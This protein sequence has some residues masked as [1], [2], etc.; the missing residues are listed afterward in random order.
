M[1]NI[2]SLSTNGYPSQ[3]RRYMSV[4]TQEQAQE[5]SKQGVNIEVVDLA[6]NI[7]EYPTNCSEEFSGIKVHRIHPVKF[8]KPIQ[9]ISSINYLRKVVLE[10][11]FNLI[12]CSFLD[13]QYIKY[14]PWIFKKKKHELFFSIM[15]RDA[16]TPSGSIKSFIKRKIKR[17]LFNMATFTF[18][19][20]EYTET[21]LSCLIKRKKSDSQKIQVVYCGINEKKFENVYSKTKE[22]LRN[23]LSLPQDKFIIITVCQ[24]IE[25]KGVIPLVNGVLKSLEE[26]PNLLHIIVGNGAEETKLR[27]LVE[28]SSFKN[29][30]I[31][32]SNLTDELLSQYFAASD[33]YAM[34]SKTLWEILATEGFG[35]SYAE[36]SY[37][38]IPVIC[39]KDGGG[40]LAVQNNFTG[41]WIDPNKN[42]CVSEISNKINLLANDI[43]EYERVSKNGKLYVSREF[44]WSKNVSSILEI[45]ET[46]KG[47]E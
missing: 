8:S 24:L 26:N 33:L 25:R 44:S 27:S 39:G 16:M 42:N 19:I 10:G 28:N 46:L 11:N 37:L 32:L 2:I 9:S 23:D 1:I 30:F 34:I 31:F 6:P 4:F 20:S 18:P 36:A 45:Y 40:T 47:H 13:S 14:L 41:F 17:H 29:N 3:K 22:E 38:G 43:G 15:G 5:F 21:L 12:K 35:I 7:N